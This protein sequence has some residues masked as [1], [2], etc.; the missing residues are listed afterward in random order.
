MLQSYSIYYVVSPTMDQLVLI[1]AVR[2]IGGIL[3]IETILLKT[4]SLFSKLEHM[5]II[6]I[7]CNPR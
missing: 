7:G 2:P 3:I 6:N 4:S 5:C 1:V